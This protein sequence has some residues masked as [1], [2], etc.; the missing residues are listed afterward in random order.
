MESQNRFVCEQKEKEELLIIRHEQQKAM[1]KEQLLQFNKEVRSQNATKSVKRRNDALA[2]S[3]VVQKENI[4]VLGDI[5]RSVLGEDEPRPL[6]L[7]PALKNVSY[8]QQLP[9]KKKVVTSTGTRTKRDDAKASSTGGGGIVSLF[10]PGS[11][12]VSKH[13]TKGRKELEEEIKHLFIKSSERSRPRKSVGK[14]LS[15]GATHSIERTASVGELP[16]GNSPETTRHFK[17]NEV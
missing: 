13:A 15:K 7:R 17:K 10:N 9:I 4:N 3:S 6:P 11:Q 16:P 1:K 2:V 5:S 14:E 12:S 8:K